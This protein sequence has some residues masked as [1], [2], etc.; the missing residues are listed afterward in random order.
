MFVNDINKREEPLFSMLD[1]PASPRMGPYFKSGREQPIQSF[2]TPI[3]MVHRCDGGGGLLA[4]IL[5]IWIFKEELKRPI[6]S[7]VTP[8][9]MVHRCD[10][11]GDLF[12]DTLKYLKSLPLADFY[13]Q[14]IVDSMHL[15]HKTIRLILFLISNE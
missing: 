4:D 7:F 2:V 8:I 14:Y 11:G 10:G 9:R 3:R 6:Q 5:K 1:A 13:K 15:V 12:N